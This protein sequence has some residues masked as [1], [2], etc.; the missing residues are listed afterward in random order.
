MTYRAASRYYGELPPL[1]T[2]VTRHKA[3]NGAR[4]DLLEHNRRSVERLRDPSVEQLV[5]VDPKGDG[6]G[7]AWANTALG[8]HK[9][10]VSGSYVMV[11]D[12][13]DQLVDVDLLVDLR[14]IIHAHGPDIVRV[15]MNHDGGRIWPSPAWWGTWRRSKPIGDKGGFSSFIVRREVWLA[16]IGAA[17]GPWGGDHRFL[18]SVHDQVESGA[19][20]V[21]WHDAVVSRTNQIGGGV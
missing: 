12:D 8:Q 13:D 15:K 14:A 1:L 11:L 2:I 6:S 10:I 5:I 19:Y 18:I 7:I 4:R 9:E 16:H 3:G 20:S 21:Y 17:A